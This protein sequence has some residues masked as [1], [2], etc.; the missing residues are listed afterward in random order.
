MEGT[1]TEDPCIATESNRGK[2]YE[3]LFAL[4]LDKIFVRS[5]SIRLVSKQ[6]FVLRAH[7]LLSARESRED[8]CIKLHLGRR[9]RAQALVKVAGGC[10]ALVFN[11]AEY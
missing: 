7:L 4:S 5:N 2:S 1:C 11:E 10:L 3:R 8:P 6:G 9:N